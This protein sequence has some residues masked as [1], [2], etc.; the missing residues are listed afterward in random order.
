MKI[1][2]VP[3][4]GKKT[5]QSSLLCTMHRERYRKYKS[6]DLPVKEKIIN[7]CTVQDCDRVCTGKYCQLH[8]RR[9]K[10]FGSFDKPIRIF[11]KDGIC[12]QCNLPIS[13]ITTY[14]RLKFKKE[15]RMYHVNGCGWNSSMKIKSSSERMKENN[16]MLNQEVRTK[17]SNALKK[18]GHKPAIQGGNGR[19]MTAFQKQLY[20]RLGSEWTPEYIVKTKLT[21]KDGYPH[22]YKI[23]I[24]SESHRIAI[25]IDGG[26]HCTVKQKDK[27]IKKTNLLQNLG[28]TVFRFTNKQI[29]N[30]IDSVLEKINEKT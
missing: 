6:F 10:R 18:M 17:V 2:K 11:M 13:N 8:R 25:E 14:Q 12:A 30:D 23:D 28:W 27:D 1:C 15:G 29:K 26:S 19:G 16:P 4:C 9:L 21:S 5:V 7:Y 3:D 22:H 24:A 20:D